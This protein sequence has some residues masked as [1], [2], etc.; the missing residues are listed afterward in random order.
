MVRKSTGYN[1][2]TII[3]GGRDPFHT[4]QYE[5]L[6]LCFF[7]V[8]ACT[9]RVGAE[10]AASGVLQG[11]ADVEQILGGW[12]I[13]VVRR[14]AWKPLITESRVGRTAEVKPGP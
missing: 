8:T 11:W 7:S 1:W 14:A 2:R 13:G 6:V 12:D 10:N 9:F 5:L 4:Q 3:P